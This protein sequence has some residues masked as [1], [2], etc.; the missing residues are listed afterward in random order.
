MSRSAGGQENQPPPSSLPKVSYKTSG[1][2]VMVSAPAAARHRLAR[3]ASGSFP[4]QR[5][6]DQTSFLCSWQVVDICVCLSVLEL[7]TSS[8]VLGVG[9]G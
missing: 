1:N 7:L 8:V 5:G 9:A 4:E 2:L 3:N 6:G